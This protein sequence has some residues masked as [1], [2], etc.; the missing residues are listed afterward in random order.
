MRQK[1]LMGF[2]IIMITRKNKS[3]ISF[4]M[5]IRTAEGKQ[6]SHHFSG[7]YFGK[8]AGGGI[9]DVYEATEKTADYQYSGNPSQIFRRKPSSE[10]EGD[11]RA[12]KK[13][14]RYDCGP[15][16]HSPKSSQSDGLWSCQLNIVN[17]PG[18]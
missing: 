12:F 18:W 14:I 13:G 16:S 11:W 1:R 8:P 2:C 5:K 15:E 10:P 7:H 17:L 6:E 4:I 3:F 9:C